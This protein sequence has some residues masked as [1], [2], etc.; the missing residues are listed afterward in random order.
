MM[1]A[2]IS[3]NDNKTGDECS[4]KLANEPNNDS[5]Y[6]TYE[7]DGVPQT[8]YQLGHAGHAGLTGSTPLTTDGEGNTITHCRSS[9]EFDDLLP[10]GTEMTYKQSA[11][12]LIFQNIQVLNSAPKPWHELDLRDFSFTFAAP[13]E[14]SAT[15]TAYMTGVA[16]NLV[17]S[18]TTS[19]STQHIMTFFKYDYPTIFSSVLKPDENYL[20]IT[21]IIPL[22]GDCIGNYI[23]EGTFATTVSSYVNPDAQPIV[24][25]D[26]TVIPQQLT[27]LKVTGGRFRF[28]TQ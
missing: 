26:G 18:D 13:G 4:Y 2:L 5:F 19:Y 24:A 11:V 28:L 9:Y 7:L 3:C 10:E 14:M 15:D 21:N 25:E 22:E 17:I 1:L 23:I 6:I 16:I 12:Y 8:F 20:N 27:Y